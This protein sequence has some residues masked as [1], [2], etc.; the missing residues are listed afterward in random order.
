MHFIEFPS[1]D[2]DL[3]HPDGIISHK[4]T[5]FISYCA[6]NSGTMTT[7]ALKMFR[8]FMALEK[9]SKQVDFIKMTIQGIWDCLDQDQEVEAKCIN[10]LE[11]LQLTSLEP[12]EPIDE[13][14]WDLVDWEEVIEI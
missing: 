5:I 3:T 10:K 11:R 8:N 14:A 6:R 12:M 2:M 13:E 7:C 9:G 1:K 4:K